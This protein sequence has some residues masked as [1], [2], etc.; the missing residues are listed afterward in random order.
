[1]ILVSTVAPV[2]D[3]SGGL[4]VKCIKIYGKYPRDRAIPGSLMLVSVKT[5]KT[6]RKVKRGQVFKSLLVRVRHNVL[7]HGGYYVKCETNGVVLLS[8]R[9]TPL[10]NRV[11]SPILKEARRKGFLAVLGLA[12]FV[13]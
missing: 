7:R 8:S 11:V 9:M 6:H 1:M 2:L 10:G 3:N 5:F 4:L 13:V 12:P